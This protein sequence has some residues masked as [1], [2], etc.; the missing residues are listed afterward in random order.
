M[1]LDNILWS[2]SWSAALA[3]DL[4]MI[5]ARTVFLNSPQLPSQ[6]LIAEGM[7]DSLLSNSGDF[8]EHLF[9]GIHERSTDK[10]ATA[11]GRLGGGDGDAFTICTSKSG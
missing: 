3:P 10:Q 8:F 5:P 7:A 1:E 9:A 11:V 6:A 2:I 4:H